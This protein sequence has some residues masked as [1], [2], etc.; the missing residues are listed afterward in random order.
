M[1]AVLAAYSNEASLEQMVSLQMG[2]TLSHIA[3]GATMKDKVFNLLEWARQRGRLTELLQ[4]AV[5]GNPA[6][7]ELLAFVAALP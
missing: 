1:A 3:G 4:G 5:D 2:E 6:S 7:P